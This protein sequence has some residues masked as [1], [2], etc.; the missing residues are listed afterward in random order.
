MQIRIVIMSNH[1][2][3]ADGIASRLQQYPQQ[4]DVMFV[5]PHQPD[6]L[7]QIKQ[8]EPTAVVVDAADVCQDQCCVICDLLQSKLNVTIIRLE[9]QRKD[10]QIITSEQRSIEEV[11]DILPI[12]AQS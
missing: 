6:Y 3:F 8:L 11:K 1:S 12:I 5:D 2:L 4:V 10:I 9:V 7:D